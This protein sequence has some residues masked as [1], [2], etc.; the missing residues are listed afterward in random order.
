MLYL[1]LIDT[2]IP[3]SSRVKLDHGINGAWVKADGTFTIEGVAQGSYVL[4]PSVPGYSVASV[5][6]SPSGTGSANN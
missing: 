6:L 5:S 4:T 2:T 1:T 3:A